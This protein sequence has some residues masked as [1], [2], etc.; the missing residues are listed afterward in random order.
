MRELIYG[1]GYGHP[2]GNEACYIQRYEQH[3]QAVLDYFEH[4][5]DDLL[6]LQLTEG[7]GWEKLCPF[8]DKPIPQCIFPHENQNLI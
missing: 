3:N 4:R 2:V 7:E 5:P 6:I 1:R 8:L